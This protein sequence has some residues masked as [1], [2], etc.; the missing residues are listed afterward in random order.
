MRALVVHDG[1]LSNRP[2]LYSL[3]ANAVTVDQINDCVEAII[4]AQQS[5]YDIVIADLALGDVDGLELVRRLRVAGIR[6]PVILQVDPDK[7]QILAVA[8]A[9]GVND[10]VVKPCDPIKLLMYMHTTIKSQESYDQRSQRFFQLQTDL[11]N[12]NRGTRGYL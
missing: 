6:T 3:T 2:L 5:N 8:L 12:R 9:I 7:A 11:D 4:L 10:I 1:S